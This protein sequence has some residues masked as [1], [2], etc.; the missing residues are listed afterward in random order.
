MQTNK[1]SNT[2]YDPAIHNRQSIRMCGHDY[3]GSGKYFVTMN[4][5][6]RKPRFGTIVKGR[7]VRNESGEIAAQCWQAIP[8]H[9]PN[10][11]LDEWVIIR[12]SHNQPTLVMLI[13]S[14]GRVAPSTNDS[15]PASYNPA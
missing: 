6:D 14:P 3:A 11:I 2:P 9:F 13:P 12:V 8:E 1:K 15:L 10:A 4:T 7:M 5:A